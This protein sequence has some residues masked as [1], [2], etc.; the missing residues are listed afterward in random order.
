MN[1]KIYYDPYIFYGLNHKRSFLRVVS[2]F[3]GKVL[4]KSADDVMKFSIE[5][6][7]NYQ[8]DFCA[9][10]YVFNDDSYGAF[11]KYVYNAYGENEGN[12]DYEEDEYEDKERDVKYAICRGY[13]MDRHLFAELDGRM[14]FCC[15]SLLIEK[16]DGVFEVYI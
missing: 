1:N 14:R 7:K 4:L 13:S 8:C 3:D 15:Y 6:L 10:F 12:D 11:F 16:E 2:P 9:L 5:T